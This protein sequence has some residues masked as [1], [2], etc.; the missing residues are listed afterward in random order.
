MP[1]H[2]GFVTH[3]F[4]ALL[5]FICG[6]TYQYFQNWIDR[7]T[8]L[9]REV[10]PWVEG[11]RK[12]TSWGAVGIMAVFVPGF[13]IDY[14]VTGK[15]VSYPPAVALCAVAEIITML[16]LLLNL[17]TYGISVMGLHLDITLT[18]ARSRV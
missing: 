3:M 11:M 2:T 12:F 6:G 7:E 13:F 5:F 4:F 10:P 14:L 18:K 1:L 17:S 9:A 15:F 8:G 16:L